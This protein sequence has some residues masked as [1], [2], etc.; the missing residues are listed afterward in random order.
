MTETY[1]YHGER[2]E[3]PMNGECQ[4]RDHETGRAI[5]VVIGTD[6]RGDYMAY[7]R[8]GMIWKWHGGA[9]IDG[10]YADG[11]ISDICIGVWDYQADE[12]EIDFTPRALQEKVDS[13]CEGIDHE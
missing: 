8:E 12:R 3:N 4:H 13:F 5:S 6:N 10:F 11:K 2:Y 1:C 7:H 9:Y